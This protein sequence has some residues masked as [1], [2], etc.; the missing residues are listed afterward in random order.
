M[1]EETKVEATVIETKGQAEKL[2]LQQQEEQQKTTKTQLQKVED[3][4]TTTTEE[5]CLAD[6]KMIV[7]ILH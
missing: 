4:S 5:V 2:Q 3:T 7:M 1:T 6:S